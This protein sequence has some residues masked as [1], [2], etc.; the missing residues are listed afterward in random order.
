[1][2]KA[3]ENK[4]NKALGAISNTISENNAQMFGTPREGRTFEDLAM[5]V[6][7]CTD[8]P[9][10][11]VIDPT[12][13]ARTDGGP[14]EKWTIDEVWAAI[15]RVV[16]RIAKQYASGGWSRSKSFDH[17]AFEDNVQN[18]ALAV[19]NTIVRGDDESRLGNRFSTWLRRRVN[20]AIRNGPGGV[21][22]DRARGLLHNFI[23]DSPTVERLDA[24]LNKNKPEYRDASNKNLHTRD[25]IFGVFAPRLYEL[26]MK[27]RTALG[28]VNTSDVTKVRAEM[29]KEHEHIS[30]LEGQQTFR[31][32]ATGLNDT[33]DRPHSGEAHDKAMALKRN[34]LEIKGEGGEMIERPDLPFTPDT[35]DK[36]ANTEIVKHFLEMARY[37]YDGPEIKTPPLDDRRYRVLIRYYGISD[38]PDRGTEHDPE[39]LP[40]RYHK[41]LEQL[42][43]TGVIEVRPVNVNEAAKFAEIAGADE[44]TY[45]AIVDAAI[46]R[47]NGESEEDA[48]D[49]EIEIDKNDTEKVKE[50]ASILG[51]SH[52]VRSGCPPMTNK[53]LSKFFGVSEQRV[54]QM[55]RDIGYPEGPSKKN[56]AAQP[57]LLRKLGTALAPRFIGEPAEGG[58]DTAKEDLRKGS[59]FISEAILAFWAAAEA[60]KAQT[61]LSESANGIGAKLVAEACR[62]VGHRT[63]QYFDSISGLVQ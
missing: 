12:T 28:S 51:C 4:L 3:L 49:I 43:S 37:G 17:N 23:N 62:Y 61:V 11:V 25:N 40:E 36:T 32:A 33:F 13:G 26:G 1:M 60:F 45:K 27:L 29:R 2:G 55:L 53:E 5:V 34:S 52:W 18:A 9:R 42:Q 7:P 24:H 6:G 31:G 20:S 35:T 57:G 54:T 56:K 48:A 59:D 14:A 50:L 8:N 16:K 41:A 30:D 58:D 10:K 47:D 63:A 39:I 21:E 44:E 22:F 19:V 46:S 15:A 38:Y